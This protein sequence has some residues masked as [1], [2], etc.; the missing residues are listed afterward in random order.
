MTSQFFSL[1][2]ISNELKGGSF[3]KQSLLS[4]NMTQ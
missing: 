3:F 4:K 2:Q 1:S